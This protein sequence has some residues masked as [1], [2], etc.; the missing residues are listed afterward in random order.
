[1]QYGANIRNSDDPVI[2]KYH[3]FLLLERALS[4]NTIEAYEADLQKFLDFIS[5]LSLDYKD[6]TLDQLR[7]FIA[8]LVDVGISDRTQAR[9]ISSVKSFYRY[10]IYSEVIEDDPTELL[11]MPKLGAYLPTVLSIEEINAMEAQIDMSKY[12]GHRNKA[13][14]ETLYGSGL[15][16]SELINIKLSDMY[17]ADEYMQVTGKGNKQRLVPLSK[18][19]I[20]QIKDWLVYR[21]ELNIQRDA[22]D[23]L[24]LNRRGGPISRI[25]IFNII[26]DLAAKAGIEK[27][28]SPHTFR[29]TFATHLLEG[30]ANL[31]DIQQLLGHESITTTEI[32]THLN[33]SY[34]RESIMK[35]HPR[36]NVSDEE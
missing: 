10:L 4:A 19:S 28:I 14:I 25:M 32:Y 13:V 3:S 36:N 29:H 26:K 23:F 6:V 16:V 21:H 8:D 9:I 22:E 2:R 34:L 5:P 20:I 1:M 11:E 33:A 24:F 30:G 17:V 15:R 27:N 31:R 35:F 7:T 12:D 18:Q